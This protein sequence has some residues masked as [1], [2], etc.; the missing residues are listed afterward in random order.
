V[1]A[2]HAAR[3][4]SHALELSRRGR[5]SS[6]TA[7]GVALSLA[8][9]ANAAGQL[10]AQQ[11]ESSGGIQLRIRRASGIRPRGS[12]QSE[13]NESLPAQLGARRRSVLLP[14]KQTKLRSSSNPFG[15]G[16]HRGNP[17]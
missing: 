15:H 17:P 16:G 3:S 7:T 12:R 8:S 11:P 1:F 9:G 2:R 4:S 14:E 5:T 13:Q 6:G 10:R